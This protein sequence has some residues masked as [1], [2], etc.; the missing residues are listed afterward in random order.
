MRRKHSRMMAIILSTIILAG[1]SNSSHLSVSQTHSSPF[2]HCS[3]ATD[4]RTAR[5]LSFTRAELLSATIRPAGQSQLGSLCRNNN[6]QLYRSASHD[7]NN[8]FV[9]KPSVLW[10]GCIDAGP[11]ARGC[12]RSTAG[13]RALGTSCGSDIVRL[14]PCKRNLAIRGKS[15]GIS[16][17]VGSRTITNRKYI[18]SRRNG[19][20]HR[21]ADGT[22]Y[23]GCQNVYGRF[24]LLRHGHCAQR[25][26]LGNL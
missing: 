2:C 15:A 4:G 3:A 16:F 13:N 10:R 18:Y 21:L 12:D 9:S 24:Q 1:C 22:L 17:G 14:L 26:W 23:A 11:V 5:S 19:Y 7:R 6:H 25:K 8:L 20:D